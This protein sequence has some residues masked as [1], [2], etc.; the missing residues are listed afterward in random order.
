MHFRSLFF[1]QEM[2]ILGLEF[3]FLDVQCNIIDTDISS[4][5]SSWIPADF[6]LS[7]SV[8]PSRTF[9]NLIVYSNFQLYFVYV[10]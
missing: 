1:K 9:Q 5:A 8:Y 4:A 3:A 6:L 7:K 2:L 10:S